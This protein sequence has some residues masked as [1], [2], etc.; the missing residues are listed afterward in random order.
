M[1]NA[2]ME[3]EEMSD[4]QKQA[5]MWVGIVVLVCYLFDINPVTIVGGIIHAGQ[6]MHQTN[7]HH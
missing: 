1:R 6:V 7:L 5:L 3:R 2:L 4:A